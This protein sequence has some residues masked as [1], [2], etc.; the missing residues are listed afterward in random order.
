MADLLRNYQLKDPLNKFE[1][2]AKIQTVASESAIG[3]VM[4]QIDSSS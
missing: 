4:T 1:L 3:G 2:M